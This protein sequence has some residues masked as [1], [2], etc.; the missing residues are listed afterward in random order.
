MKILT[1]ARM[2]QVPCAL[3]PRGPSLPLRSFLAHLL[4]PGAPFFL[5]S[6]DRCSRVQR[7]FYPTWQGARHL[8]YRIVV[9]VR[10]GGMLGE[11]LCIARISTVLGAR[12]LPYRTFWDCCPGSSS[13]NSI[14][15]CTKDRFQVKLSKIISASAEAHIF[16]CRY[17]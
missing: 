9:V 2:G 15:P 4:Q 16:G 17:H 8:P 5:F 12:H 10:E 14:G 3:P 13:L 7:G 6:G 1:F 11:V